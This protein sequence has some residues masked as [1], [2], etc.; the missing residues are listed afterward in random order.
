MRRWTVLLV[1]AC[2]V[3][4]ALLVRAQAGSEAAAPAPAAPALD[5]DT[6]QRLAHWYSKV[7]APRPGEAY[8]DFVAR[9]ARVQLGMPYH[10]PPERTGAELM[11]VDLSHFE[12]VSLVESSLAVARCMW[13]AS[14]DEACFLREV[15]ASRYRGGRL[16]GYA[17]RLH[18]FSEWLS[19]N[20]GR[21]R[22]TLLTEQ[23]GG[24]SRPY[25]FDYISKHAARYPALAEPGVREA[26]AAQEARLSREPQVT[27]DRD[28]VRLV[29]DELRSG[30]IV[31]VV[32]NRLSGL[33]IGHT[34]FVDRS[35][36]GP[37]RLM[38]A[39]SHHQR[40]IITPYAVGSYVTNWPDRR[41]VMLAR[42]RPPK[43]EVAR[44]VAQP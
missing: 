14:P 2:G 18:Y 26:M 30:D 35:L 19:D 38:H 20:A 12:C 37:P 42:P 21:D 29:H 15:E 33:L 13:A 22:V 16:D 44:S 6:A 27:I 39:S 43:V 3:G 17:S 25:T 8:G 10:L 28:K 31:A 9:V 7:G 34:S 41:G 4:T 40:V 24:L 36:P 1:I 5:P 23:L 32:S 11:R